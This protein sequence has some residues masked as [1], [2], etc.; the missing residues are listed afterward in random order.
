M[1]LPRTTS[2]EIAPAEA[3]VNPFGTA[4]GPM[5]FGVPKD[6]R[7]TLASGSFPERPQVASAPGG[8]RK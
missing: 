2:A 3:P 7:P 4:S 5:N 6:V 1:R 8:T